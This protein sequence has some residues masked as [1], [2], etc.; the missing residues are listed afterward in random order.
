M[1]I[2]WV[3]CDVEAPKRKRPTGGI[4]LPRGLMAL[5]DITGILITLTILDDLI[6]P[7]LSLSMALPALKKILYA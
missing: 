3:L 7:S 6:R 1:V 5:F 4:C 2:Q